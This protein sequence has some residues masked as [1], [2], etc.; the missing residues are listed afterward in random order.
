MFLVWLWIS[1]LTI[2]LGLEFDAETVRQR[3]IVG[4]YIQPRDTRK[5]AE[6]DRRRLGATAPRRRWRRAWPVICGIPAGYELAGRD[7]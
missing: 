1:N 2:L 5:W 3:A 4:G 7:P 6:E